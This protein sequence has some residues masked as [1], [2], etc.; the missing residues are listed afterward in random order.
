MPPNLI[1]LWLQISLHI[2]CLLGH[3]F[4]QSFQSLQIFLRGLHT[5]LHPT[6]EWL[7]RVFYLG[8]DAWMC[9]LNIFPQAIEFTAKIRWDRGQYDTRCFQL[10]RM[11]TGR[12]G[13][14]SCGMGEGNGVV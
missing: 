2:L 11:R 8:C 7:Q 4:T 6:R 9:Y 3:V 1:D 10:E 14:F 5:L 13:I 12:V